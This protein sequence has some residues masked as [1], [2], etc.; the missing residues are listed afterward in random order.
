M[1]LLPAGVQS[2]VTSPTFVNVCAGDKKQQ[3]TLGTLRDVLKVLLTAARVLPED[4][5]PYTVARRL[6]GL[7]H[8][9][10]F[11]AS[12][13]ATRSHLLSAAFELLDVAWQ[14]SIPVGGLSSSIQLNLCL[15]I[16]GHY[17]V[18]WRTT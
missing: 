16:T 14:R 9:V 5:V 6:F 3:F 13:P 10:D 8:F 15:Y 4:E 2:T 7:E 17:L 18:H 12:D 11:E 1:P